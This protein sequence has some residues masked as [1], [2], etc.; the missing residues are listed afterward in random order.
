MFIE[1][2]KVRGGWKKAVNN[3]WTYLVIVV[4]VVL[5]TSSML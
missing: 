2:M 3:R 4:V 1:R 5:G